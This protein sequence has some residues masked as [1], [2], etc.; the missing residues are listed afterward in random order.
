MGS[1]LTSIGFWS[2][3]WHGADKRCSMFEKQ[4]LAT[5]SALQAAKPITQRVMEVTVKAKLPI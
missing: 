4:L 2:Q 1:V 3:L 5:Y